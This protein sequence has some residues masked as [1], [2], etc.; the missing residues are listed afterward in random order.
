MRI[1]G[2]SALTAA[3]LLAGSAGAQAPM[4]EAQVKGLLRTTPLIDGHNDLPWALRG[5]SDIALTTDLSKSTVP[6]HTDWPRARAGGLGAQFWSVYVSGTLP[7]REQQTQVLEQID[8]VKRMVERY[9]DTLALADT[10]DAIKRVHRG[11]K[12]ASLIGIEGGAAIADSLGALREFRRAGVRYMTLT[13]NQTTTWADAASDVPTHGGLSPFGVEVVREMNRIGMLVDL[14]HVSEAAM[15]DALDA[16]TA[17]VIFSHSSARTI[18]DHPRNVPD[19]VLRRLPQNGGVVMVNFFP[20]FTNQAVRDWGV[21][22][23]AEAA[24]LRARYPGDPDL[25]AQGLIAW[26]TANPRPDGKLSDIADHLDHIRKVAGVDHVG[27]GSDYDGVDFLPVGLEDVGDYPALLVELSRRG[28]SAADLRKLAGENV[29]R[30]LDAADRV[31]ARP[32]ASAGASRTA[33]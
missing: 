7:P 28:W 4:S 17:P 13:H 12:I 9:P 15:N 6:L 18:T 33:P 22:Q 19:A 21:A 30:V 31:A 8:L 1:T 2:G 14:S 25:I 27:I 16:S 11:G 26:R 23:A 5:K 29:L 24:R 20:G 32:A 3:L 10:A